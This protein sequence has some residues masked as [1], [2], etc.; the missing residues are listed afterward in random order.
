[1]F[2]Q[3]P[4]ALNQDTYPQA[5]AYMSKKLRHSKKCYVSEHIIERV[6]HSL[7]FL[8]MLVLVC[9][10]LYTH[11]PFP[12]LREFFQKAPWF[13]DLWV[14]I[15][16]SYLRPVSAAL[17]LPRL[18]GD[19]A[20][21]LA[22][23]WGIPFLACAVLNG[24]V[25]LLYWP[26]LTPMPAEVSQQ[27]AAQT[28]LNTGRAAKRNGKRANVKTGSS[29]PMLFLLVMG[30]ILTLFIVEII[31]DKPEAMGSMLAKEKYTIY[32][33]TFLALFSFGLVSLPL[34]WLLKLL[35]WC[36]I[37]KGH[38]TA[39][40]AYLAATMP[41]EAQSG[42]DQGQL[43]QA[44][45]VTDPDSLP[46]GFFH[47]DI[48]FSRLT[49]FPSPITAE[50]FSKAWRWGARKLQWA[51]KR[52]PVSQITNLIAHPIYLL[53][54]LVLSFGALYQQQI[55]LVNAFLDKAPKLVELWQ[56][57][58]LFLYG[59][60]STTLQQGIAWAQF[61][62]LVP[63]AL[64][65]LVTLVIVLVYHPKTK[66]RD[67]SDTPT[68]QARQLCLLLREAKSKAA[69]PKRTVVATCNVIFGAVWLFVVFGLILF[70][71]G[72]PEFK[73]AVFD[74]AHLAN[75][76]LFL[77]FLVMA[78]GY[79]ILALPLTLCL[80]LLSFT[81]VPKKALKVAE[82]WFSLCED[83]VAPSG[84]TPTETQPLSLEE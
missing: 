6:G 61:L 5:W 48:L 58:R 24:C 84:E 30:V 82:D 19:L 43:H 20:V 53:V 9:G 79:R 67:V 51:Q 12:G 83:A 46:K 44:F 21:C 80:K 69:A 34:T 71:L 49:G 56:N 8:M 55:P 57:I 35:H 75:W 73:D 15:Y 72:N 40:E 62:Y 66:A 63:L 18:Y 36:P 32:A 13:T 38:F 1:M 14:T 41:Q 7:F 81:W 29:T 16:A 70:A 11:L 74:K 78:I 27:E 4:K 54:L 59:T 47:R 77:V 64:S 37:P 33:C 42:E 45:P 10:M 52:V 25:Q 26:Q 17:D 22:A 23:A 68:E 65:C 60:G 28:L 2:S 76:G 31:Q 50:T 39:M 3:F